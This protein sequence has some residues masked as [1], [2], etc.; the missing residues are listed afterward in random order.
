MAANPLITALLADDTVTPSPSASTSAT[1]FPASNALDPL[2]PRRIWKSTETHDVARYTVDF[3]ATQQLVACAVVGCNANSLELD[4]AAADSWPG[5]TFTP[6]T[7]SITSDPLDGVS[8][9]IYLL[10]AGDDSFATSGYRYA[11][12]TASGGVWDGGADVLKLGSI[13]F[14]TYY[15]QW[16]Y[17]PAAPWTF[18][19]TDAVNRNDGEDGSPFVNTLGPNRIDIS[20][21]LPRFHNALEGTVQDVLRY[22]RGD[23][24]LVYRN[25]SPHTTYDHE[26]YVAHR[27]NLAPLADYGATKGSTSL[28]YR[29]VV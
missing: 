12:F 7:K 25:R 1:G 9:T 2:R 18:T 28:D 13:I 5:G 17:N 22:G 14:L 10:D 15:Q 8:K 27:T 20:L 21:P 4:A 6:R 16:A 26:F 11:S 3:G 19:P 24:T 23:L 29:S